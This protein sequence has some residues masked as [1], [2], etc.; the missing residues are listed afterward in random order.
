MNEPRG[1]RDMT[2]GRGTLSTWD[3]MAMAIAVLSP[4]A[5]MAC[6]TTGA[7]LFGGASTPLAFLL[8][9]VAGLCLSEWPYS[10]GSDGRCP[11]A[12]GRSGQSW[13]RAGTTRQFVW[14]MCRR[15]RSL[16]APR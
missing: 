11:D 9:G 12:F 2:L 1:D 3:A 8:A 5:A 7:A 15:R 16:S 13:V 14:L 10:V 4:A 6:N